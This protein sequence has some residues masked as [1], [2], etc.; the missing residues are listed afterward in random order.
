MSGHADEVVGRSGVDERV[1]F[2]QK[3]FMAHTLATKVREVLD[4]R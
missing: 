1:S 2:S 3:P 4:E